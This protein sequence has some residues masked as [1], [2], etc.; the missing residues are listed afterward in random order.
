MIQGTVK[1]PADYF[2]KMMDRDYSDWRS[3]LPREF[4]QNSIDAR[5]KNIWVT[6]DDASK[7]I[8][9]KDDGS[10]MT[11][12]IIQNKLLVLGGSFKE[13]GAVGAFGKAKELLYFS[14]SF[15]SIQT[16][17]FYVEGYG[18]NYT[19]R[20][21]SKK[22]KGT[23][24]TIVVEHDSW[25]TLHTVFCHIARMM[26]TKTKIYVDGI[27]HRCNDHL[28]RLIKSFSFG[29]LYLNKS[30]EDSYMH[31]AISGIWMH[32]NYLG[33]DCGKFVLNLS[34]SSV[35]CL[36]SNRDDLKW[37]YKNEIQTF[38][39]Q[40]M[41]NEFSATKP[42]DCQI[43]AKIDGIGKVCIKPE[44]ISTII[45][46]DQTI[47]AMR[48]NF[49]DYMNKMGKDLQILKERLA[50]EKVLNEER[51][52]FIGYQPDFKLSYNKKQTGVV[53]RFMKKKKA[54]ILAKIWTEVIK[55]V[56]LD[57]SD[58]YMEFTAGF[59]FDSETAA[60]IEETND[61]HSFYLNPNLI[62]KHS[63]WGKKWM[64]KRFLLVE[65]LKDKAIHEIAHLKWSDHNE[66]FVMEM[67][68]IRA[69]TSPNYKIYSKISKMK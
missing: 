19:I 47:A 35:E 61:G 22:I 20:E 36:T 56:L 60:E 41:I 29:D 7:K 31:V 11:L 62:G 40:L 65:E 63:D 43:R 15:W 8:I 10:G 69:K 2:R 52:S 51:W 38:I 30:I 49:E 54:L 6:F 39:R 45:N 64:S 17:N 44:F 37:Q 23:I 25:N 53:K 27:Q 58:G 1:V 18:P 28:G 59:T 14:W 9:I 16:K 66:K 3:A 55:Q 13:D 21:T 26:N 5:A 48:S 4:Y 46:R 50:N 67:H 57:N 32:N 34:K 24:S 68:K 12:D 42:K 33:T